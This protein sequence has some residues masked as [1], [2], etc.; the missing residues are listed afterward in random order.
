MELIVMEQTADLLI[1]ADP[2]AA[3]NL[4]YD[5]EERQTES[6]VKYIIIGRKKN[7]STTYPT[8]T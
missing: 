3:L 7:E 4:M 8:T 2:Q 5:S 1:A 6:G